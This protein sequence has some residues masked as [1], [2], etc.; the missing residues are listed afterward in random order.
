MHPL[1][2]IRISRGSKIN[3]CLKNDDIYEGVLI[4][5]DLS[6]NINLFNVLVTTS[7]GSCFYAECFVRGSFIKHFKVRNSIMDVQKRLGKR[8]PI[9][10]L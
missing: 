1:T 8:D 3:V 9:E 4:K 10:S 5:C 7:T 6:M 2:L